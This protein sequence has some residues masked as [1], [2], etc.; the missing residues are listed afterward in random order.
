MMMPLPLSQMLEPS[1]VQTRAAIPQF[2]GALQIVRPDAQTRYD[3]GN[4]RLFA[5]LDGRGGATRILLAEGSYAGAWRTRVAM[6]DAP[7]EFTRARAIGRLWELE[8]ERE[9]AAIQLITWLEE[10]TPVILQ[11]CIIRNATDRTR[12]L[13]I[14][15]ELDFALPARLRERVESFKATRLAR[16]PRLMHLWGKGLAKIALPTAPRAVEI[17]ADGRVEAEG[18]PRLVWGATCPPQRMERRGCAVH[19]Q[20]VFDV[21]AQDQ[22]DIAWAL[23]AGST[24]DHHAALARVPAAREDARTYAAWLA[25]RVRT[26]DPLLQSLF[27]AG[28]NAALAM[29]KEFP[30]DFAGLVAGPDYAY[31]PRLYFRDGYWTAQVLLRFRPDLV[32][33]HLLSLARGVH[34]DGQCPSGI[35]APH[36]VEPFDAGRLDWL[37]DHYDAPAFFVLLLAD[38]LRGTDDYEILDQKIP[39]P[40]RYRKNG[41]ASERTLWQTAQAA[42]QYLMS[43]DRDGDGL[44]EKP[45][46]P[47]D[48]CDNIR[49]SVWVTY[50][51]ALYAAALRAAA[52]IAAH[53]GEA[54][55]AARYAYVKRAEAARAALNEK[56]WDAARGHFV[57]YRREGFIENHF[58]IDTLVAL[59]Y[60]LVDDERTSSILTAARQL[61]TRTNP[62]QPFGDWGVMSVFPLYQNPRDLFSKSAQPYRYHNGADWPYW[63]G[64]YGLILWQRHDPDWR[65]VL[66][67]WWEYGLEQGWLTPVEY[68]SPAHPL[69]GMLQGWSAMPAAALAR[70]F[71]NS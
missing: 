45:Y 60:N 12:R 11:Q 22:V 14:S 29:F 21:P 23:S 52:I 70:I 47:N 1:A 61:Q 44:I 8:S 55:S 30:N 17:R 54:E 62:A 69:G 4:R 42:L 58:S 53:A 48:W 5:T 31:P 59:L 56:L 67:R 37:P 35:F 16:L 27:V 33:R 6:D 71:G 13:D 43:R 49:R 7:S 10:S 63:D 64:V 57:N 50:D 32:R 28:L 25:S 19:I 26:D 65:Y 40:P 51:Q 38:Y 9:D 18:S 24:A 15:I 41:S 66:T 36:I 46:A 68:F 39:L 34:R 20:F 2:D 3:M